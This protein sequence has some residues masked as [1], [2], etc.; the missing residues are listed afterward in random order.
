MAEGEERFSYEDPQAFVVCF[1]TL[2]ASA[3]LTV[4]VDASAHR[5]LP[6]FVCGTQS[7]GSPPNAR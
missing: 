6:P 1:A 2:L 7:G 4:P 5:A 3:A